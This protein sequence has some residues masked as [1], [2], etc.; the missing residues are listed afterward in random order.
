MLPSS[1]IRSFP[2]RRR[3]ANR[4]TA[5]STASWAV[6]CTTRSVGGRVYHQEDVSALRAQQPEDAFDAAR[7]VGVA[8][9]V[10]V[11][12]G[13]VEVGFDRV[14]TVRQIAEHLEVGRLT[15]V[16]VDDPVRRPARRR[17]RRR[18]G[19][20]RR[21]C[22]ARRFAAGGG[23]A[24]DSGDEQSGRKAAQGVE[25]PSRGRGQRHHV[26]V[27]AYGSSAG[28]RMSARWTSTEDSKEAP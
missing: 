24:S 27:S 8:V 7:D 15:D 25:L 10:N 20:G 18:V 4:L 3:S 16:E 23:T 12:V 5:G 14:G 28:G 13:V 21:G 22:R 26:I 9:S 2:V 6:A 17:R 1:R 19:S 11:P